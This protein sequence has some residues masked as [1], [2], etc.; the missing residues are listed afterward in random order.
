MIS[1]QSALAVNYFANGGAD[2]RVSR[3]KLYALLSLASFLISP[4]VAQV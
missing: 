3:G 2:G 1:K 4:F